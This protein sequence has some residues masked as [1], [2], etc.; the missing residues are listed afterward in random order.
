MQLVVIRAIN[1]W[2]PGAEGLTTDESALSMC[3]PPPQKKRSCL[4]WA[5][6]LR[7]HQPPSIDDDVSG[8][9]DPIPPLRLAEGRLSPGR[10]LNPAAFPFP[11]AAPAGVGGWTTDDDTPRAP[12]AAVF[13]VLDTPKPTGAT[14]CPADVARPFVP[15]EPRARRPSNP[16]SPAVAL[17]TTRTSR[18]PRCAS[19]SSLGALAR[20]GV[21]P[22]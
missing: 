7:L 4:R 21:G 10:H 16:E 22:P 2:T 12:S 11:P 19:F 8:G 5:A 1:Y 9:D 17:A 20:A 13:F 6:L 14:L 18:T 15:D 3:A